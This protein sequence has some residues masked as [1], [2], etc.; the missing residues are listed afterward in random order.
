MTQEI[1][2]IRIIFLYTTTGPKNY[3]TQ[4]SP[5]EIVVESMQSPNNPFWGRKG[6]CFSDK[7]TSLPIQTNSGTA[8]FYADAFAQVHLPTRLVS[9]KVWIC[10]PQMTIIPEPTTKLASKSNEHILVTEKVQ[11]SNSRARRISGPR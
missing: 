8:S 9:S 10:Y 11:H 2:E 6:F 5:E 3:N 4:F 7:A 1:F